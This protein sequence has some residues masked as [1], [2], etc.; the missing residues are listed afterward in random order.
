MEHSIKCLSA[1]VICAVEN[2]RDYLIEA[3]RSKVSPIAPETAYGEF[4]QSNFVEIAE[5]Y[6]RDQ[7]LV[8]VCRF[9]ESDNGN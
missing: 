8:C 6:L 2:Q 7:M 1:A 5:G 9:K 3:T 4:R